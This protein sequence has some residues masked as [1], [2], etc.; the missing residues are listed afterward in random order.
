MASECRKCKHLASYVLHGCFFEFV[1]PC[2]GSPFGFF[3]G[4]DAGRLN[5]GAKHLPLTEILVWPTAAFEGCR[6]NLCFT[7]SIGNLEYQLIVSS[8]GV[9]FSHAGCYKF[10]LGKEILEFVV[11]YYRHGGN[12]YLCFNRFVEPTVDGNLY[13]EFLSYMKK[14][15]PEKPSS[16]SPASPAT[17]HQPTRSVSG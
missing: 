17:S 11:L 12:S 1:R 14:F 16:A 6:A 4:R 7:T 3:V 5:N 10:M 8:D 2:W 15:S 9:A 13:D